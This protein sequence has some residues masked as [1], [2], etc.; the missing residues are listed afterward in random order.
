MKGLRVFPDNWDC[1]TLISSIPKNGDI[2]RES[3]ELPL[4]SAIE[5]WGLDYEPSGPILADAEMSLA[6]DRILAKISVKGNFFVP[7]SRCLCQTELAIAGNLRYL[8]TLRSSKDEAAGSDS[9]ED[10]PALADGD[11]D[12]IAIDGFQTELDLAPF[13]WEV[14]LLHLPERAL[15]SEDCKGLCPICGHNKNEGDCGC[16]E[17]DA[18]PR[19]DALRGLMQI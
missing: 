9:E 10:D 15:C 12:V 14:L 11:A 5:H 19:F 13:V 2:Y 17:N 8:F 3:F 16:R 18:D 1:R 7:C 4:E 6:S